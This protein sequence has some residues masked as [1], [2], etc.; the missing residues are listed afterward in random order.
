MAGPIKLAVI[1]SGGKQAA[2]ELTGLAG[3]A[4]KIG[5]GMAKFRGPAIGVLAAIGFG[6]KR[7]ADDAADLNETVS[8]GRQVFGAHAADI[9]RWAATAD[10]SMGQSKQAAIDAASTFGLIGQKAGLSGADTAKFSKQF[11][12]LASD[13]ASFNNTSPDEA[14]AA[15]GAA[16][17][18]ESEP[19]RKYGVLLDD[20]TLRARA[21]KMG[22]ID[23]TKQ[24]L[25]PQQK[26]LAASREILAQTS[27]AQGD[28]ARTSDGVA[29]KQRINAAQAKNLSAQLGKSLLPAYSAI[30]GIG[31]RVTGAMSRH[32]GLVKGLVLAL[33][34]VAVAV[35]AA[36][37]ATK[38]Y[39]AGM[40]VFRGVAT[41]V[42]IATIVWR[43]AQLALNIAM[44]LNPVGVII[45]AIIAFV[46]IIVLAYK[47]VGW[48]RDAVNAAWAWIKTN[49]T[50][51]WS[52]I[53]NAIGAAWT[54][55][56]TAVGAAVSAVRTTV[57]NAWQWIKGATARVWV[58]IKTAALAPARLLIAG[59][60]VAVGMVCGVVARAWQWVKAQTVAAWN[61]IKSAVASRV[62]ALIDKVKSIP[63]RI[64][65]GLSNLVSWMKNLG[66]RMVQGLINALNSAAGR[67]AT[68]IVEM[69]KAAIKAAKKALGIHSPSRVFRDEIGLQIGLGMVAGID[70]SLG[71]VN[72]A[73]RRLSGAVLAG[74]AMPTITAAAVTPPASAAAVAGGNTYQITVNVPPTAHPAD[75]GRAIVRA[76]EA[77]EAAGGGRRK[78]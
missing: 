48:F 33:A 64:R 12:G 16:M 25:T 22:L 51:A 30:L 7:A 69:V 71:R 54:W 23:S 70:K 42:K 3:R 46:A 5:G 59:V 52:A 2:S 43:N 66:S 45:A 65:S 56:K 35:L 58:A 61:G 73:G 21:M 29:N 63:G 24:A 74:F 17:R 62:D 1:V 11:V 67:V 40:I 26:A 32:P 77:Y 13:M 27:K 44:Y 76:I 37:A 72:R 28:F 53:C 57:V 78:R 34:G 15:I 18:G 14:V 39:T 19:I 68:V 4:E 6:A 36:S 20:A 41:A 31:Q 9:E 8:K 10:R 55:I 50:A 49:A 75:T 38:I 47:K 60:R